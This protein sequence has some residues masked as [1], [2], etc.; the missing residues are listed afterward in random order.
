MSRHRILVVD[1]DSMFRN[2]MMGFLRQDY[3][4]SVA[5]DGLDAYQK[6]LSHPPDLA[7]IDVQMPEWDGVRTLQEFRKH[8]TLAGIPVMMLTGD[9]TKQTVI[10]A[11]QA[12]ASDYVVKTHLVKKDL[13]SKIETLLRNRALERLGATGGGGLG[14][15]SRATREPVPSQGGIADAIE[16]AATATAAAAVTATATAVAAPAVDQ[17]LLDN[18]E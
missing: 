10:A 11:V 4:V 6:A 16:P 18:W 2:L 1:D 5:T 8:P 9:A 7:I 13:L 14:S 17:A 15:P 3:I 12:G